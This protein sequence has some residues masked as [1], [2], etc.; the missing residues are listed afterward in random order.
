MV[1]LSMN[2]QKID[3][4]EEFSRIA[5]TIKPGTAVALRVWDGRQGL[6]DAV[7]NYRTGQ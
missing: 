7:V 5:A 2:G 6:G 4:P 1:L 3:T